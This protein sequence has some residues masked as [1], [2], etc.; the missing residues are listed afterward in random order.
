MTN[1]DSN[2]FI[3]C[4]LDNEYLSLLRPLLFTLVYLGKNPRIA[5]ERSDSGENRIDKICELISE[6]RFG[7]H[8][9]SRLKSENPDEFY[10]LN[11]P[12]ELGI[13]YGARIFGSDSMREKKHLILGKTP[14]NYKIA[15]SD[16]S[17]VDI[18]N[19]NDEPDEIVRAVRDWFY[20][21]VGLED[22]DSPKFIWYRFTDF[23]TALFDSRR[24]DEL[25]DQDVAED[26]ERMPM[27][28]FL[29]CVRAWVSEKVTYE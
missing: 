23:S 21:T 16:I 13:D 2:V 14:Y 28:E 19:H 5:T 22:I 24:A 20:E 4:P 15:L 10:R 25:S 17:G 26:I 11:M 27:S 6:S 7:I 8:D 3:N 1:F 29:G 9:L 18:K 12:F